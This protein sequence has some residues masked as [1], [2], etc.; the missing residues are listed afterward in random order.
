MKKENEGNA[1]ITLHIRKVDGEIISREHVFRD[2]QK[3][4]K[5]NSRILIISLSKYN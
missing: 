2:H 4:K 5:S 3:N 1:K